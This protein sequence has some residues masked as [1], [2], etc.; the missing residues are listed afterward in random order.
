[1]DKS[2]LTKNLHG[3]SGAFPDFHIVS[4]SAPPPY[5]VLDLSD[6]IEQ[7]GSGTLMIDLEVDTR[8]GEE[9]WIEEVEYREGSRFKLFADEEHFTKS[10]IDADAHC[11]T[12]GGQ[13]ASV[14]SEKEKNEFEFGTYSSPCEICRF[15]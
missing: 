12:Q 9:G 5:V 13:F 4:R 3:Y 8:Q 7:I 1:M 11:K 2:T 6:A 10:W 15:I 14:L